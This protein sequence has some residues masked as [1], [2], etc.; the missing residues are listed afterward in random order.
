MVIYTETFKNFVKF[1]IN[2]NEDGEKHGI[3]TEYRDNTCKIFEQ[4]SW[5]NGK[6]LSVKKGEFYDTIDGYSP[7]HLVYHSNETPAFMEFIFPD[8]KIVQRWYD[9]H[10]KLILQRESSE[11]LKFIDPYMSVDKLI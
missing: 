3:Q 9:I 2:Y 10:G 1:E 5:V 7:S 4:I 6:N 11:F 8:Y